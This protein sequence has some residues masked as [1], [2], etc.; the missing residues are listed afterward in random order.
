M[1]GQMDGPTNRWT[2]GRIDRPCYRD[3]FLSDASKKC[4][5]MLK[6][7]DNGVTKIMVKF[8][9]HLPRGRNVT[10]SITDDDPKI[11]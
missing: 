10:I 11:W 6:S 8:E 9:F 2:N 4:K 5:G 3:A 7:V 1:Y